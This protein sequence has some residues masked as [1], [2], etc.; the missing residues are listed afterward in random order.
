MNTDLM[1]SSASS[2]WATPQALFDRLNAEY[3]F[4]LDV[5]ATAVNAKCPRFFTAEQ[6]G[7]AQDWRG[8]NCWMNPPYGKKISKWVEKAYS[9]FQGAHNGLCVC[10]LPARTDTAWWH[11]YVIK[12]HSVE[13]IRGRLKFGG[14]KN[15]APFP[16]AI[17]VFR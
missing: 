15:S 17:A 10:L 12:A 13:F 14:H 16:S 9:V 4:E 1:F 11:D 7:L 2:E 5:C 8:Q 3:H 6:D